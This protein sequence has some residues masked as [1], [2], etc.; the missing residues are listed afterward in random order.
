VWGCESVDACGG[1][2]AGVV[3]EF[4]F[5]GDVA[6]DVDCAAHDDD[7]LCAEESREL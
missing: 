2:G 4:C 7:F 3:V 5:R 1:V 6:G